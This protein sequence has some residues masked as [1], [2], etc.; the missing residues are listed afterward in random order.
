MRAVYELF[1]HLRLHP[2]TANNICV[3]FLEIHTY[4][5]APYYFYLYDYDYDYEIILFRHKQSK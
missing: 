4:S 3:H 1:S 5:M 2:Y